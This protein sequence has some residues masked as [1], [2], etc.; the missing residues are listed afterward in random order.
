[1]GSATKAAYQAA[2]DS[3]TFASGDNPD[4][5]GSNPTRT[6]TWLLNDG[7]ASHNL[8]TVQTE[9]ISITPV[10]DPPTLAGT[11]NAAFTENGAPVTLSP[12]VTVTDPDNLGLVGATVAIAGGT[13]AGDG[14]VLG[15]D[16]TGTAIS[17]SY[18]AAT[19]TLTLTGFDTFA[20]YAK[21]LDSVTFVTP[22]DNPDD[23]GSA[24]TR[25]ISWPLNDGSASSPTSTVPTTIG[26]TAI[27]DAPTLSS[28][29]TSA[30]F[31]EKGTAVTLAGSA[32]VSDV[33]NL[34]LA[35]A[36]V[37]VVAGAFAGDGDQ[38]GAN[39]GGTN[40]PS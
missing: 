24:P 32:S 13:F 15:F 2:L 11:A 9:T 31:T 6:V 30:T 17:A 36:T 26:I 22:S 33:D 23:Y 21:V 37:K 40:V 12:S 18:N 29:Q 10:N 34:K 7:S 20:D 8:S 27:N 16:T 14:D 3:L 4:D 19:E 35:N 5:F 39:V 25:T 1:T 38:V 28:I